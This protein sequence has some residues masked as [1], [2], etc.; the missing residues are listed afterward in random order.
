MNQYEISLINKKREE[1]S[2]EEFD[3][4]NRLTADMKRANDIFKLIPEALEE[5]ENNP[6]EFINKYKLRLDKSDIFYAFSD[7]NKS[8]REND[9]K[10]SDVLSK[11]PESFFRY[12]QYLSNMLAIRNAI[13]DKYCVPTDMAVRKWRDRQIKRCDGDIGGANKGFIHAIVTY[14]MSDGCSVNCK[15][16]G[17]SAGRLQSIFRYNE[18]NAKLFNG[19]LNVLKE[20]FGIA[21]GMGMMYFASEALD[22]PDYELFEADY[23]KIFNYIPQITTAVPTRDI[24]RTKRLIHELNTKP[25]Y[26][27]RFSILSLDIARL[28]IDKFSAEELLKVELLPQFEEAPTFVPYTVVGKQ[29]GKADDNGTICCIDGFCINFAKKTIKLFTPCHADNENPN[30]IAIVEEIE[31]KDAEDFARKLDYLI[32]TY[33]VNN[34]P[35]GALELYDYYR[36]TEDAVVST[37]GGEKL[38]LSKLPIYAKDVL[39]YL[40]D[41]TKNKQDIVSSI[42]KSYDD[43]KPENIFWFI[44]Q[45]WD[46]GFIKDRI[47]FDRNK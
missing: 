16:C 29:K 13:R 26:A 11:I 17:L 44:N 19:V 3:R 20:R 28:V 8:V 25:S 6:E 4:I 24:E 33:M 37:H 35:E 7:A 36:L 38:L 10:S 18:E 1:L 2:E 15:F 31:F 43:I 22:N 45:L 40:Q 41:G 47:F 9:L 46:M 5:F 30:G 14:E 34:V 27:H 12:N 42:L 23:F 39:L 21:A 32:T